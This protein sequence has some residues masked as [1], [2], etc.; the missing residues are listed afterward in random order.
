M[1]SPP[2]E[3]HPVKIMNT[4]CVFQFYFSCLPPPL[5][6]RAKACIP[7]SEEAKQGIPPKLKDSNP[8]AQPSTMSKVTPHIWTNKNTITLFVARISNCK[9]EQLPADGRWKGHK[10]PVFKPTQAHGPSAIPV[11]LHNKHALTRHYA[12][13]SGPGGDVTGAAQLAAKSLQDRVTK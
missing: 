4:L 5:V 6:E 1:E 11:R 12:L 13:V 2:T 8:Q 3:S 10:I 9:I 7:L